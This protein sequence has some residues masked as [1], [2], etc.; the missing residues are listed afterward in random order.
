MPSIIFLDIDGVLNCSDPGPDGR[1]S[2]RFRPEC[3]DALRRILDATDAKIV[4][5]STHR[6]VI[7]NGDMTVAGY[8]YL[9]YTHGLTYGCVV[10][11][12]EPDPDEVPDP[13]ALTYDDRSRQVR[14]W[15]RANGLTA[16]YVLIDDDHHEADKHGH[17]IVQTDGRRG[18]T[19]EDADRAI[20]ILSGKEVR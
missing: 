19:I 5:S 18:L 10:G 1:R 11:V 13:T 2:N 15:I 7:H 8:G 20:A 9:L 16:P 3:I 6:G 14:N 4:L 12:T 17:P